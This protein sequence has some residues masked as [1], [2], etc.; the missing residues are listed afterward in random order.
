M[1]GSCGESRRPTLQKLQNRVA[2]I[3]T[4]SNYDAPADALIQRLKWPNIAEV[5][6]RETAA[7]VYKSLNG[8]APKY[9]SNIFSK[10][11][12]RGTVKL[13]N[14]ETDLGIP[15]LKPVMAKIIL[16][17]WSRSVEQP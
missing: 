2:R 17:S 9:L 15:F 6:K 1:W 3:A 12:S 4:N 11:S 14:Y 13:I 16:I 8:L 5:I 10:K 7:I